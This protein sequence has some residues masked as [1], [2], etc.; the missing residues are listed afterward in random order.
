MLECPHHGHRVRELG[1]DKRNRCL[2]SRSRANHARLYRVRALEI[3]GAA[4]GRLRLPRVVV[5]GGVFVL[6]L[7]VHDCICLAGRDEG[8]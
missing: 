1:G 7:L 8:G 2:V 6:E 5:V 4:R 3:P